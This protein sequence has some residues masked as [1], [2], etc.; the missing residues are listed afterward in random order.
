MQKATRSPSIIVHFGGGKYMSGTPAMVVV[1]H[2][3]IASR[4]LNVPYWT[5]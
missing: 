1:I 2:L 5:S 4:P 3:R